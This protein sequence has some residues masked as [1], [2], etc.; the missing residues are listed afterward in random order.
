M[1]GKFFM[2]TSVYMAQS[3]EKA[4]E[5]RAA[6][7]KNGVIVMLRQI[8]NEDAAGDDCYEILVPRAE[9]EKALEIIIEE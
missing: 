4:Q 2:W 8:N 9:V 6:I 7:E 3:F 5:L 1:K